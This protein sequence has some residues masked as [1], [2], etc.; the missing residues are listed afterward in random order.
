VKG[1]AMVETTRSTWASITLVAMGFLCGGLWRAEVA[2]H[3]WTGLRS[4]STSISPTGQ[5][6]CLYP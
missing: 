1:I 4:L 5:P 6:A 2:W 3:G